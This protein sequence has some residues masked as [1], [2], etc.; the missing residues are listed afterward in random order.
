MTVVSKVAVEFIQRRKK[1]VKEVTKTC[2]MG[3]MSM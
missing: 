3:K 1:K 2:T